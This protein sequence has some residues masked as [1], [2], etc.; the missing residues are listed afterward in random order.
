M[1]IKDGVSATAAAT[2]TATHK[3]KLQPYYF[4]CITCNRQHIGCC[5]YCLISTGLAV[6]I[7]WFISHPGF[8]QT[9][10]IITEQIAERRYQEFL[11]FLLL[12]GVCDGLT[13]LSGK[14]AGSFSVG[15]WCVYRRWGILEASFS[16]CWPGP[17]HAYSL[18]RESESACYLYSSISRVTPIGDVV[19]VVFS[20]PERPLPSNYVVCLLK[21]L[22]TS[23]FAT[24]P[25]FLLFHTYCSTKLDR[26]RSIKLVKWA[27]KVRQR[28][29]LG[30]PVLL[31]SNFTGIWSDLRLAPRGK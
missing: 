17:R 7:C 3:E 15:S 12:C 25:P 20:L 29:T 18:D 5:I 31:L 16:C 24:T 14:K 22:N 1:N 13:R 8:A 6:N 28:V 11:L 23:S 21:C 9:S 10:H 19:S 27:K 4:I 2:T 26:T 30:A